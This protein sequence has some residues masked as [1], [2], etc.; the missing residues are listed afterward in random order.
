M[1][2]VA[3]QAAVAV[4]VNGVRNAFLPQNVPE[5]AQV[6]HRALLLGE[7]STRQELARCIVDRTHQAQP[8][9]AT[10]EPVVL[11]A[12]PQ[13][14]LPGLCFPLAPLPVFRGT[15]LARRVKSR[16]TQNASHRLSRQLQTL[17]FNELLREVL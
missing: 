10:L 3:T 12:V 14:H 17:N 4:P 7:M 8:R 9:T 6:P 16:V 1:L 11:A 15:P 13:D 2:V 5:H